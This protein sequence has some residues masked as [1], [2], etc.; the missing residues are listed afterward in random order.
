MN[1]ACSSVGTNGPSPA[2]ELTYSN[3][4]LMICQPRVFSGRNH[5]PSSYCRQVGPWIY[6]GAGSSDSG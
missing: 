3:S 1:L 6:A 2:G 5:E 4:Q